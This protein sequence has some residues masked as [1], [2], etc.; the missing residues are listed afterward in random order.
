MKYLSL[1][2]KKKLSRQIEEYE[3]TVL[4]MRLSK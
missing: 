4:Q 2:N 1:Q 3:N